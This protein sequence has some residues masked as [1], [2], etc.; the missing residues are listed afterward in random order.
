[1]WPHDMD[2]GGFKNLEISVCNLCTVSHNSVS[3]V[4]FCYMVNC[5]GR[6]VMVPVVA[7]SFQTIH[8]YR[9]VNYI[10]KQ[11]K[12]SILSWSKNKY[13]GLHC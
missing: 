1:M 2:G 7:C 4:L 3:E 13:F 12:R 9:I 5:I 8:W 10:K 6:V 11:A